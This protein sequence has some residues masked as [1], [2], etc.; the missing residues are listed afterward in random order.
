[1]Q[2]TSEGNAAAEQNANG[3][4]SCGA[5]SSPLYQHLTQ[6]VS[7]LQS[8]SCMWAAAACHYPTRVAAGAA[9]RASGLARQRPPPP[10]QC[11]PRSGH[12]DRKERGGPWREGVL[13]QAGKAS[14]KEGSAHACMRVCRTRTSRR[15]SARQ[16]KRANLQLG[17]ISGCPQHPLN[18][19]AI[20]ARW[21]AKRGLNCALHWSTAT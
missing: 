5:L 13:C 19:C 4:R 21:P 8:Q 17:T 20:T 11:H 14:W 3:H 7:I 9:A 6:R 2:R 18:V 15:C 12:T 16:I 10:S 1:M